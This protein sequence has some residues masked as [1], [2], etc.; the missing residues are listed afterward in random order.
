MP[1]FVQFC[2]RW[3]RQFRLSTPS[4]R[5]IDS[6]CELFQRI[7]DHASCPALACCLPLFGWKRSE[8]QHEYAHPH[9]GTVRRHRV[10][11]LTGRLSRSGGKPLL[12]S[13]LR[14]VGAVSPPPDPGCR[15]LVPVSRT[16][17]RP[18][19]FWRIRTSC[20]FLES[21][22]QTALSIAG[23]SHEGQDSAGAEKARLFPHTSKVTHR[24]ISKFGNDSVI[25]R[26]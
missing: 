8:A 16:T 2:V 24:A 11:V 7:G 10:P 23:C 19:R 17:V 3:S 20:N 18:R 6:I 1:T 12:A 13:A 5:C 21:L 15:T 22:L 26:L 14:Y 9:R 4:P 25:L